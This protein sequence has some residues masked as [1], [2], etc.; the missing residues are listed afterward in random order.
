MAETKKWFLDWRQKIGHILLN[1]FHKSTR[2]TSANAQR[3]A[4]QN[5][6][7]VARRYEQPILKYLPS[8]S[9]N[10]HLCRSGTENCVF[11][12]QSRRFG[13]NVSGTKFLE[14]VQEAVCQI[15]AK[16]VGNFWK[17]SK[18]T[19]QLPSYKCSA[20]FSI[21]LAQGP[22]PS[23]RHYFFGKARPNK[24]DGAALQV[25]LPCRRKAGG[26]ARLRSVS[27]VQLVLR[28]VRPRTRS[29]T[30]R[31][32]PTECDDSWR[33]ASLSTVLLGWRN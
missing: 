32:T 15:L 31:S 30:V 12:Q 21:T 11:G 6:S 24:N 9:K 1:F 8:K 13:Q 4:E 14:Y 17:S 20:V 10:S 33:P 19:P 23:S 27:V 3:S 5:M 29:A 16:S 2:D 26:P 7:P 25:G 18:F 28:P 22:F